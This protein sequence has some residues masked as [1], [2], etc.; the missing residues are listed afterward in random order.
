[1]SKPPKS[2][3]RLLP[4]WE[5]RPLLIATGLFLTLSVALLLIFTPRFIQQTE[6]YLYDTMLANRTS[7]PK[8]A[9]PVMVGIDDESLK[10]YGQWP[11][12]RYRVAALVQRLRDLGAEVIALD[13]VMPEPDRTSPEIIM[14]ERERD[15]D[16]SADQT[17]SVPLD[18][19][20]KRLADTLAGGN[21]ILGYYFEFYGVDRSG[22]P[23]S[24][25]LPDG[26]VV[27]SETGTTTVWPR[28]T[29]MLRSMP[30][31]T[32]VTAAEGFTNARHDVD[33]VLRRVP[34][35]LS[36]QGKH[37]PSLALGSILLASPDRDLRIQK[38]GSEAVLVWGKSHIPLDRNGNLMIDFRKGKKAFPYFSAKEV[39]SGTQAAESLRG[40]I[41]LV[42]A[43]A[44]GLGDAHQVPTVQSLNGLEV[45]ATIIDNILSGT[46]I[47]RPG[48]T[49]GAEL[50]TILLLGVLSTLL[51]SQSGFFLSLL[52]TAAGVGGCYLGGSELLHSTGIVISPLL[53]MATP[54]VIMTALS[55]LKY[56][57]EARKVR[58]RN[59]DLVEA[60]NT[61]IFSMSVLAE[62]RDAETGEHLLR[63]KNY[64][65]VLARHLATL[66]HYA[67][68]DEASI[69]L[70]IKSAPLHDIGKIGIPDQIL[71]KPGPLSE[72][73]YAIIKTHTLIGARALSKT[74]DETARPE[75]LDFLRYAR[76]MAESHHEKWDGS[77]YPYGL[78]GADIPLAGRLMAL[79]DVYDALVSKRAYKEAFS[80]TE[81]QSFIVKE[82]GHQ[83]DPEVIAAFLANKEEFISI[84]R[85]Y[86]DK[87]FP[88]N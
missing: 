63:T 86:S 64:V 40:K 56:G 80:H 39:L 65:E 85:K 4:L 70:L 74:I 79:A 32:S 19:N 48:W 29:G 46:F 27:A 12:P 33:G 23:G 35:L 18:S 53:P 60:Q 83:F 41:V 55:L 1:M 24:P 67:T 28:P 45:H 17:H 21:V 16:I 82:T 34:L 13:F 84:A 75:N 20:S 57:I 2:I 8:T 9:V 14:A 69:E 68:L 87:H 6:L 58:Q 7:S 47:S 71:H 54:L 76:Q 88:E 61:I 77:G 44:R 15:L 25:V 59:C 42:G 72:E 5:G 38:D 78:S 30:L 52:T 22:K 62:E 51:L 36:Y 50:F 26:M 11:W 37:F 10:A 31:L 81:A 66:P 49:R 73:E 3:Q 43:W